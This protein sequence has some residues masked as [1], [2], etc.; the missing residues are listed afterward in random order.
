MIGVDL[1]PQSPFVRI[2]LDVGYRTYK[3]TY[4]VAPAMGQ[5]A[6]RDR[7]QWCF[8]LILMAGLR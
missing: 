6:V 5:Y 3:L 2:T 1:Q 8:H 4:N 7:T